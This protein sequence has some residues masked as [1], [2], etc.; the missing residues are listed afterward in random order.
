MDPFRAS[1]GP[2]LPPLS[3]DYT[4]EK[5]EVNDSRTVEETLDIVIP[6]LEPTC[7][8]CS[9]TIDKINLGSE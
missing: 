5:S 2:S 6:E 1:P 4:Q 8:A 3:A 7:F 9:I